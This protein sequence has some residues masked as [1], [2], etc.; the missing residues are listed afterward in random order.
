M[1]SLSPR[2]GREKVAILLLALGEKLG[3]QLLQ[4]FD[5]SQVKAIMSSAASISRVEKQDL[6]LLVDDFAANFARALGLGTDFDSVKGMVE[7]AFSPSELS[8]MLGA[9]VMQ[10]GEPA[11]R[12]FESGMENSLVPYL[13]DEHPQ[14]I[15]F[16]LSKLEADFASRCLSILPGD[17]RITV[18]RRLLKVQ[19]VTKQLENLVEAVIEEDLLAKQDTGLEAEG[20]GRLAA[21][22]NKL[23]RDQSGEILAGVAAW[24]PE[25][26]AKLK[27]MI[28]SFEDLAK[29]S[30]EARLALFD[31]LQSDQVVV[32]LRGVD[33]ALKEVALSSL[34]ARARRMVEAELATDK[35]VRTK[36]GDTARNAIVAQ[37]LE[38]V[39]RGDIQ[40][41]SEDAVPA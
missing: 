28:F 18:A 24:K 19:T 16:I 2:G 12:R 34:G 10:A 32:A 7:R 3:T 35:G 13:L 6:D 14:T 17:F 40:L 11:W 21:M 1:T 9:H 30:Q 4:K 20:R 27:R 8:R 25:E 33:A 5:A 26:A 23:D 41:P 38:M 36:E 22:L 37:V 29:L 39:Q 31:K 15:A